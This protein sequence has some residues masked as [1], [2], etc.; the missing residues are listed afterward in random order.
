MLKLEDCFLHLINAFLVYA[1]LS[2]LA[3]PTETLFITLQATVP[4]L[5][6]LSFV[7]FIAGCF[8]LLTL[9]LD[10]FRPQIAFIWLFMK[11]ILQ[12]MLP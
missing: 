12:I 4:F 8:Y 7:L 3:L 6:G 5:L 11:Q 10:K 2:L 1:L 9:R